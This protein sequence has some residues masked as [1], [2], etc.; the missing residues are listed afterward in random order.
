[1][2]DSHGAA[3]WMQA[4]PV[5]AFGALLLSLSWLDFHLLRKAMKGVTD[6]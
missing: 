2:L 4:F 6:R 5:S 1:L 3:G